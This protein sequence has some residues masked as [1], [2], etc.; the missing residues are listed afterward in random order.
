MVGFIKGIKVTISNLF[1]V[2][3]SLRYSVFCL[4]MGHKKPQRHWY[5]G[6]WGFHHQSKKKVIIAHQDYLICD[7]NVIIN[8]LCN[9]KGHHTNR[10]ANGFVIEKF[11]FLFFVLQG[12]GVQ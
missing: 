2:M 1:W 12:E 8:A 7:L 9:P 4:L 5:V 10:S 6:N 3:E 11:H